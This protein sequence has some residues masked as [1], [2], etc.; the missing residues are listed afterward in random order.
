VGGRGSGSVLGRRLRLG[1]RLLGR[2]WRVWFRLF[3]CR[4]G[5]L[6]DLVTQWIE[7]IEGDLIQ[8]DLWRRRRK[9]RGFRGE[10]RGSVGPWR[11]TIHVATLGAGGGGV[12]C[13]CAV[14]WVVI[15][16]GAGPWIYRFGQGERAEVVV[17]V[18]G[19][20]RSGGGHESQSAAAS[21]IR[22]TPRSNASVPVPFALPSP[23]W[24]RGTRGRVR[25]TAGLPRIASGPPTSAV[26]LRPLAGFVR[27][28][29]SL[30]L[31][32]LNMLAMFQHTQQTKMRQTIGKLECRL[33]V[34]LIGC[35]ILNGTIRKMG[36]RD[37]FPAGM[38]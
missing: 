20:G 26:F 27:A 16:D 31:R 17:Q 14:F 11:N 25:K 36:S 8:L 28:A 33:D 30:A 5:F 21:R 6:F 2:N 1:W 12:C 4:L 13:D 34:R 37:L 9:R 22:S 24:P 38:L 7:F 35:L 10:R 23:Q 15:V 3:P 19:G 32:T 18:L 29:Y